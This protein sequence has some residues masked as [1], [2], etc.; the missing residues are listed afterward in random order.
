[1]ATRTIVTSQPDV[2]CYVCGRRL[3]RGEQP[4][5]FLAGGRPRTVCELC[6]PRAANAGWAREV[7]G[8][9][10]GVAP[11]RP[12]RGR[13]IFDRLRQVGRAA[14]APS[15]SAD[16]SSSHDRAPD[17]Y[18][19]LDHSSALAAEPLGGSESD[20]SRGRRPQSD[21]VPAAH[22]D[23]AVPAERGPAADSDPWAASLADVLDRSIE[24]FNA[25]E[26][27]RR[28][29]GL[30]RS[31][32]VPDV[33][34]RLLEGVP[35]VVEIVVAWELCWYRYRVDLDDVPAEAHVRAQG[36]DLAELAREDLLVNAAVNEVGTLSLSGVARAHG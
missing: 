32:G 13:G 15:R 3:L 26:Y 10:V 21:P 14:D 8:D 9:P 5:V 7:E 18:D 30:A 1:M 4:E 19:F 17:G 27:P 22:S 31:L 28:V 12:R 34:V 25:G 29:A 33:S 24:V 35:N 2:A 23:L 6:A 36:T 16:T 11:L 20:Q